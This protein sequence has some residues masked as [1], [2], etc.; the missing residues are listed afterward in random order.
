MSLKEGEVAPAEWWM[1]GAKADKVPGTCEITDDGRI[2]ARLHRNP[3]QPADRASLMLEPLEDIPILHGNVFGTEVTLIDCRVGKAKSGFT[4]HADITLRPWFALEG[5]LLDGEDL[6]VSNAEVRLRGQREWANWSAFSYEFEEKRLHPKSLTYTEPPSR[7]TSIPGGTLT[8]SDDSIL[9]P[10][11]GDATLTTQCK[12]V[13]KLSSSVD[14]RDFLREYTLP[15]EILMSL[16]ITS[17]APIESF[18]VSDDRWEA[19][20][21]EQGRPNWLRLWFGN[22]KSR[23]D[24]SEITAEQLLFQL[25][26][27]RWEELGGQA[28]SVVTRWRYIIDQ[29]IALINR[30]Y[31]WPVPRFLTAVT[32]IEAVDRLLHPDAQSE[33]AV[34][35]QEISEDVDNALRGIACLNAKR[36]ARIKKLIATSYEPSL[37]DRLA[38]LSER[39]EAGMTGLD[40]PED[41]A[42]RVAKLR[43][44]VSHG[45]PEVHDLATDHRAAQVGEAILLHLLESLFL[46]ELGF[47]SEELRTV[48]ERRLRFG[49]RTSTI[50]RGF[51]SLPRGR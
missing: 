33:R 20:A 14:I 19:A 22:L 34:E 13:V 16:A 49:W 41:W 24:S 12:F 3:F 21:R 37:E 32:I 4:P 5:L 31:R 28:F 23:E 1:P 48:M 46:Y 30:Q 40:L 38:R 29:W 43:N 44:Q 45:L 51:E 39:V 17:I 2:V 8:I 50:T 9:W 47:N 35:Y 18:F 27:Y 26:D 6:V 15:L 42:S 25:G 7:T 10:Q 11:N 36:R